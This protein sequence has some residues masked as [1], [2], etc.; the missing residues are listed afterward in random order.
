MFSHLLVPLDGSALAESVLSAAEFFARTLHARLTLVHVVELVPPPTVHGQPHLMDADA[1]QSY[2]DGLKRDLA[3]QQID[4]QTDIH[5]AQQGNVAL[6]ILRS[7][8]TLSA[9]L[10]L[11]CS[12]GRS[13]LR[14][15]LFGSIAQQVLQAGEIPVFFTR[16]TFDSA[17]EEFDLKN[18]LVPLDGRP[19]YEPALR[20][21]GE[22][23]RGTKSTLHLVV[24]VPTLQT[25][26]PE[27]AATGTLLPSST[28]AVLDLAE[29]GAAEYLAKWL[30][31]FNAEGIVARG[32]V[33]RGETVP[34]IMQAAG[35]DS[36]DLIVMATHGRAGLDA[37]WSGSVAPNVL[38]QAQIP[39]L[40][41]RVQGEEP[42][43]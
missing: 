11:L 22:L 31:K 9:D 34:Q 37:F 6:S 10:I 21:A 5:H 41:L 15:M 26:S 7:A 27:R 40:L 19:I 39:T 18:M 35:R 2:L 16:P 4:V 29:R 23:A 1:A 42:I 43:R 36:A 24:V 17:R 14:D 13:G 8:K 28:Q 25:L 33:A 20:T 12:H 32:E 38:R 3:L 30:E